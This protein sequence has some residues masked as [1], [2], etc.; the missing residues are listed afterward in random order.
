LKP[1]RPRKGAH[2]G[3]AMATTQTF[4]GGR[5]GGA[6]WGS[7]GRVVRTRSEEGLRRGKKRGGGG[8]TRRPFSGRRHAREERDGG[9]GPVGVRPREGGGGGLAMAHARAGG[10][11]HERVRSGGGNPGTAAPCCARGRQGKRERRARVGETDE[12]G[13]ANRGKGAGD[14]W[15]W[16]HCRWFKLNQTEPN[17]FE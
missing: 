7:G 17:Q 14:R 9:G 11:G 16:L 1:G 2:R 12:W 13:L 4:H 10:L 8:V 5:H 3:A 6:L 15:G